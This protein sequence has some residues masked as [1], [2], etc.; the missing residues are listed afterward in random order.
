MFLYK[1]DI[2]LSCP[3]EKDLVR[4]EETDIVIL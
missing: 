3:E 4:E 1:D 2:F